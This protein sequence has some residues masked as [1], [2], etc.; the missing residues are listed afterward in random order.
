MSNKLFREKTKVKDKSLVVFFG[1]AVLMLGCYLLFLI[2]SARNVHY[3]YDTDMASPSNATP[4]DATYDGDIAVGFLTLD[5]KGIASR[6]FMTEYEIEISWGEVVP[7]S[8]SALPIIL[9]GTASGDGTFLAVNDWGVF[10]YEMG[11]TG[12][13]DA[14][15]TCI[16]NGW[17]E[18]FEDL[19]SEV[20]DVL[21]EDGEHEQLNPVIL[22]EILE[23]VYQKEEFGDLRDIVTDCL[24]LV[25]DINLNGPTDDYNLQAQDLYNQFYS[26]LT[27][28][29]VD[30]LKS[31][32][33]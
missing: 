4:G 3:V 19:W 24:V 22:Q 32:S 16:Q 29:S 17:Q 1:W 13:A 14:Y 9:Y 15:M 12:A 33:E 7:E 31:D 26:W 23:G 30:M 2:P 28:F 10:P 5:G 20:Y 21:N 6:P 27:N 8:F 25:N 11:T 18:G